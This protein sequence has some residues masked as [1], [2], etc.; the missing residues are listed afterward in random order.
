M[1]ED[2][3]LKPDFDALGTDPEADARL[4]AALRNATI[5]KN[6]LTVSEFEHYRPLFMANAR[7]R[8]GSLAYDKL[9]GDWR[10]RISIFHPV[11]IISDDRTEI[12]LTL[13]ALFHQTNPVN[14]LAG[15]VDAVAALHNAAHARND[16]FNILKERYSHA[17]TEAFTLAQEIGAAESAAEA[18]KIMRDFKSAQ[19]GQNH[20][21]NSGV[22][23]DDG[24]IEVL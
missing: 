20:S 14:I 18:E 3:D 24:E 17:T 23:F 10:I 19:S 11:R 21:S 1:D 15:G 16:D 9:C 7:D 12:L 6:T 13:P 4:L 22:N 5:A 2:L 8:I